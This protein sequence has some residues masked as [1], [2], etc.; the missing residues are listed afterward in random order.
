MRLEINRADRSDLRE[1]LD[2]QK[3]AFHE[4]AVLYGLF[5]IHPLTQTMEELIEESESGVIL[6]AVQNGAIVGS[7]RGR[8]EREGCY[9]GRLIVHPDCRNRGIGRR[10]MTAIEREF[11]VGVFELMTGHLDYKNISLY[12]KLGYEIFERERRSEGL[13]L[14]HMRKQKTRIE[15]AK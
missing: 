4:T 7:V 5:D 13:F 8:L 3:L 12:E 14:I 11:D 9:I 15:S 1:I 6:K 2:L 10:L